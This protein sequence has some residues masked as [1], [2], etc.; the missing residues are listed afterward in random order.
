LDYV[1]LK[2]NR[3]GEAVLTPK[4]VNGKAFY[5]AHRNADDIAPIEV[6]YKINLAQAVKDSADL[7][8][9]HFYSDDTYEDFKKD[10]LNRVLDLN[11]ANGYTP[12]N[13]N[14]Q[15]KYQTESGKVILNAGKDSAAYYGSAEFSKYKINLNAALKELEILPLDSTKKAEIEHHILDTL[16]TK[17]P[18][19]DAS[20]V[21]LT[22]I[23]NGHAILRPKAGSR[24]VASQDIKID[25]DINVTPNIDMTGKPQTH[26]PS[27]DKGTDLKNDI[28]D[29]KP[30]FDPKD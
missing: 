24:Y 15:F 30:E 19:F 12:D 14:L 11:N 13:A 18:G 4:E 5:V 23:E 2:I 9:S 16:E 1:D 8:V 7:I 20:Q 28:H 21:I 29:K 25:F 27:T 3:D 6:T 22:N 17:N 10:F 26:Q